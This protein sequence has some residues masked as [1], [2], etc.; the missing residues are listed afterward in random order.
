MAFPLIRRTLH[1]HF[2]SNCHLC[3]L[4]ISPPL[5]ET[6]WCNHC[7]RY[8]QTNPRCQQCGLLTPTPVSQC[9][10]CLTQPPPWNRLYCIGD[11]RYPLSYY[12]YQLKYAGMFQYAYDLSYL[13]SQHIDTPAPLITSVPLHWR[14]YLKRGFNQSDVIAHYLCQHFST[15]SILNKQLFKRIR[16]TPYQQ[17]LNK[18]QRKRNLNNAFRLQEQPP[19][20][21]I[22]IVDDVVTTGSTVRHLCDLLLD[23]GVKKIDIYSLCRTP[24]P[25]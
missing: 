1:H 25:S 8:F 6:I 20:Q 15:P 19:Y 7:L 17:G 5:G 22:A 24:E 11:Y 14:R 9:G 12:V 23:V 18:Q 2:T 13:L 3:G 21:H 10:R 4:T 16:A